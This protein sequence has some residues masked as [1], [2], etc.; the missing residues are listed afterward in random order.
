M[1]GVNRVVTAEWSK[2]TQQVLAASDPPHRSPRRGSSGGCHNCRKQYEFPR[3]INNQSR[4]FEWLADVSLALDVAQSGAPKMRPSSRRGTFSDERVHASRPL[5][6]RVHII[7]IYIPSTNAAAEMHARVHKHNH[8]ETT[9]DFDHLLEL[10]EYRVR[11]R[12]RR[13]SP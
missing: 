8:T 6:T 11:A 1:D 3:K 7:V 13:I 12:A 10:G 4:R 9:I 5:S 2:Q